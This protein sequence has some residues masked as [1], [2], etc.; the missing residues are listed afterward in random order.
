MNTPNLSIFQY[1]IILSPKRLYS[2]IAKL[3]QISWLMLYSADLAGVVEELLNF[4]TG[5]QR[6]QKLNHPNHTVVMQLFAVI[7]TIIAMA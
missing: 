2:Q 3:K 4:L 1:I 7:V 5:K 6:L